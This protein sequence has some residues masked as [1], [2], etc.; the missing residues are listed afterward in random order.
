[1]TEGEVVYSTEIIG[2][3]SETQ[4]AVL[5]SISHEEMTLDSNEGPIKKVML[6]AEVREEEKR[7]RKWYP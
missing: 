4:S 5:A 6:A 7:K 2:E 1:M 3:P